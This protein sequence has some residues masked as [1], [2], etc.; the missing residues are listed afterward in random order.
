MHAYRTLRYVLVQ[1][2]KVAAPFTPFISETI[3]CNLK[4]EGM[5]E[6]VHLCDFPQANSEARDEKLERSMTLVQDVVHM[7]RQLRLENDLKV[8]QPLATIHVVSANPEIKGLLD[9][10][11]DLFKDEL[12]IKEVAYGSDETEMAE[13]SVKA[14]F[15]KLGPRF[16]K[17]M[18]QVAAAIV[19]LSSEQAA[20][21]AAGNNVS[22]SVGDGT[23][24]LSPDDVVVQRSPKEGMVV[25]SGD[26]MLVGIETALTPELVKEGLAR[27]FISR[28]QGLRKDAG[29]EVT[30]RIALTI[31]ADA[32]VVAAVGAHQE[33]IQSETLCKKL[34]FAAVESDTID[35]NG[36][37]VRVKVEKILTTKST[38]STKK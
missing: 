23:E 13:V 33:Y 31:D 28:V 6:S 19:R 9:G 10:Y 38:K 1:V 25:A 26:H 35:L 4:G 21:L 30:Q 8:R 34:E 11:E 24:E 22:L 3:Y 2:S 36:H 29:F 15:R 20:Q 12:N 17:Q 14:D 5:P 18:K 27:E 7:G 32:D 37:D 16:G